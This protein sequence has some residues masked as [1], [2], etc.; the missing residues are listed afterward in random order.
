MRYKGSNPTKKCYICGKP[1][2][3]DGRVCVR[4]RRKARD[5]ED[6]KK[7]IEILKE[8]KAKSKE[9]IT[10]YWD[11]SQWIQK[12]LTRRGIEDLRTEP[13]RKRKGKE[14]VETD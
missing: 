1:Y 5:T 2:T 9:M 10:D 13:N 12:E 6:L 14:T 11:R 3:V 8:V 4:C 7:R